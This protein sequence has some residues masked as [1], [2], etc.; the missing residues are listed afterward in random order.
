MRA[1]ET[2]E[3]LLQNCRVPASQLVGEEGQGFIQTLQVL[4][5]GRIGIAALAVVLRRARMKP[6]PVTR[7]A[8]TVWPLDRVVSIHPGAARAARVAG[9]GCTIAH[10]S[11]GVAQ[12]SGPPHD[13]RIGDGEVVFERDRRAAAEDGV[14]MHG[15]YGFVKDYPAEKF[16]RDVKLVRSAKEPARSSAS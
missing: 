10:L 5:A 11:G 14:Q 7:G 9:R 13:A 1:S 6:R 3:V 16:F 2:T 12:G 15:G 4:D 8:Q